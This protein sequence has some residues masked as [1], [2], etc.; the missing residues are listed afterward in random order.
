MQT[1][2]FHI[3]G[4]HCAGCAQIIEHILEA[5][6]G[7][8]GCVVSRET[9]Q[10]RVAFDPARISTERLAEALRSSGYTATVKS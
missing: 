2:I 8:Q 7:V 10:A 5:S 3:G 1:V 4:M 9:Q 6:P